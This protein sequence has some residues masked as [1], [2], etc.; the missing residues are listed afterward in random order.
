MRPTQASVPMQPTT[1]PPP[2]PAIADL[3]AIAGSAGS[4]G[5]ASDARSW[6]E[7]DLAA[8][9]HNARE[10][11]RLAGHPVMAV[12]KANGYGHGAAEV[13]LALDGDAAVAGFGVA[14][15]AEARTLR[16][17]GV[18]AP[19]FVLGACLPAERPQAVAGGFNVIVSDLDEAAGFDAAAAAQGRTVDVHLA[20][21]TGMG[22]LG[23]P[24]HQWDEAWMGRLSG[25]GHLRVVGLASHLPSADEDE[26]FT[27][28]QAGR[29]RRLA[30]RARAVAPQLRHVHLCNSAGIMTLG[31]RV[32]D[33]CNLS[34]PGL[35][36]YGVAPVACPAGTLRPTLSWHT[37]VTLVRELPAGHGISYGR[38]LVT[39]RPTRVATL[40]VGY[41]DGYPRH[42]SGNGAEVLVRG[43][44]CPLLGRV[45]MDQVM[46]DVGAVPGV[47]RPGDPAV[48]L[49]G[50]GPDQIDAAALARHAGTIPWEILT[51][52]SKRVRRVYRPA[53]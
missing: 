28:A 39:E 51:G 11:A 52:I 15:V 13:A 25:F 10:A 33:F 37:R 40:A 48:L 35:M 19:L 6:V 36:L 14:G 47:V 1:A 43:V 12:V 53:V 18:G 7:I 32:A 42:L 44:R 34:R 41:G 50:E 27:T 49:G 31:A 5:A 17:A 22:R 21:D 9:R 45:T 8:L 38:S 2:P 29:F 16:R 26:P 4:D 3:P 30:A 24:E 20:I 46:V 23:L